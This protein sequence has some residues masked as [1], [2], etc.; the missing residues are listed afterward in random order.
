MIKKCHP[1][2]EK[3]CKYRQNSLY[4]ANTNIPCMNIMVSGGSKGIGRAILHKFAQQGFNVAFFARQED[5]LER[6]HN[7][8]KSIRPDISAFFKCVD[9]RDTA[10]IKTFAREAQAQLGDMDVLINNV[11]VFLPG[12]I[13]A[14]DEGVLE[15]LLQVNVAASYHLSREVVPAMKTR[16]QGHVFN[17]CSTAS[18]MAY[19]NGGSYCI[20]KFA[21]LGM[22]KVLREELKNHQVR[23]TAVLPGATLTH[24]WQGTSLPE[25]RFM[26]PEDV[27][28]AVWGCY[29]LKHGVVEELLI[30]PQ[31]GDI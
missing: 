9:A 24:S 1:D 13:L 6:V 5:E 29:A 8:L 17:I 23:V 4:F 26:Q 19:T 7:E 3:P 10:Q 30:R 2:I 12:E 22:S 11:G 27:A 25:K 15:L 16:Q 28:E 20:S 21:M 31:E 14:E 18:I